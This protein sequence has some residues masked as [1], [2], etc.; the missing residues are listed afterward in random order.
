M[1][2]SAPREHALYCIQKIDQ[3]KDRLKDHLAAIVSDGRAVSPEDI[4][5]FFAEAIAD[6]RKRT[7]L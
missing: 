4:Q 5:E 3:L 2:N 1:E 7:R 6:R